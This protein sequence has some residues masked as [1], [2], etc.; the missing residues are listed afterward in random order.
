MPTIGFLHTADVHVA[1]FGALVAELAPG[2]GDVHVTDPGLLEDA[3]RG[4]VTD[5]LRERIAA[6]LR[7]LA[8]EADVI[9][10][11]CS[12]IGGEAEHLGCGVA[13]PVMRLD[14]PM[15]EAAVRVGRRVTVVAALAATLEPTRLLLEQCSPDP[16]PEIVLAPCLEAW[17]LFEAGNL[18]GYAALLAA[19]VRAVAPHTDAIV[20]AQATM[21]GVQPLV[22]DL[23]LP[24][25]S[26][27]RMGVA[28]A[29]QLA[30]P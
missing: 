18:G 9:V 25:F 29:A 20:L 10:C 21:G 6:H 13:M 16:G 17:P 1:T 22:A 14:R 28:S 27:P 4:G 30:A 8:V 3:C 24:V 19:H 12:T 11:T 23:G 26:S 5:G 15:A 2:T 7:A